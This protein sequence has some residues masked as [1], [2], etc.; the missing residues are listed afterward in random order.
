MYVVN[1][2]V[3]LIITTTYMLLTDVRMTI[4]TLI[5][6]PIL[7]FVIYKV[8]SII[9][10]KSKIMQKSQSAIS[11]FVQDSFSG[12]R[13]VKFFNKEKYIEKNYNSKVGDYMVKALDRLKPK[14][15]FHHYSFCNRAFE[16]SHPLYWWRTI[17]QW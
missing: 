9:N 13:V 17:H 12:I 15:I 7:S 4:W 6:L 2:S 14:L 3:L 5:P 10:K 16:C 8:S 11:T 1:L